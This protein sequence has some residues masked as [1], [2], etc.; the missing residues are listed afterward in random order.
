MNMDLTRQN[1]NHNSYIQYIY[2]YIHKGLLSNIL[3]I[4][5]FNCVVTNF[6]NNTERSLSEMC[7]KYGPLTIAVIY[8]QQRNC[9]VTVLL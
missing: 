8:W 6:Y 9:Y 2:V 5:F 1:K 3:N 4:L 7:F